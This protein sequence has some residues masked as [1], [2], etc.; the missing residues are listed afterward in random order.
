[1]NEVVHVS[2][3]YGCSKDAIAFFDFHIAVVIIVRVYAEGVRIELQ[4]TPHTRR[5]IRPR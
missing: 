3:V 4:R 2:G 1:V 5:G